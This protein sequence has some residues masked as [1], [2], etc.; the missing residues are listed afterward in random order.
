ML[1]FKPEIVQML[2]GVSE[3]W[4]EHKDCLLYTSMEDEGFRREMDDIIDEIARA[5]VNAGTMVDPDRVVIYL[6]LIHI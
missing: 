3:I 2:R 1:L 6:S 4:T 5:V